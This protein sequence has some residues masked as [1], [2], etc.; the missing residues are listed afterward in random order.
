MYC[1]YRYLFIYRRAHAA[2]IIFSADDPTTWKH[3]E[4]WMHELETNAPDD[5]EFML[6]CNKIDLLNN[7][8]DENGD[9]E[10]NEVIK[11]AINV[12]AKKR[13]PFYTTSAKSGAY[14]FINS[15]I[16]Y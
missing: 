10:L 12:A 11:N 4:Y 13:V 6:I 7:Q 2:A 5:I 3:V 16:S 15:S 8:D 9:I 14:L 1:I